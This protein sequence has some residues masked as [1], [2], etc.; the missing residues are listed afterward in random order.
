MSLFLILGRLQHCQDQYQ[1]PPTPGLPA[2]EP[3]LSRAPGKLFFSKTSPSLGT[4]SVILPCSVT[5]LFPT[6]VSWHALSPLAHGKGPTH[7]IWEP[8]LTD[9]EQQSHIPGVPYA[10]QKALQ[11]QNQPTMRSEQPLLTNRSTLSL[12][13]WKIPCVGNT[14][15]GKNQFAQYVFVLMDIGS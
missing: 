2:G 11:P 1:F 13:Q 4:T 5:C 10:F 9:D 15:S 8:L 12:S 6:A 14:G 7:G 3:L